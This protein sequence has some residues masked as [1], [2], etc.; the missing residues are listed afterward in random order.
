MDSL[1]NAIFTTYIQM[2]PYLFIG[3]F[4]A[5]FMHLV[6]TRELVAKHLGSNNTLSVIKAALLGVP[7]PLCSCGVIPTT[8]YLRKQK[9][10]P[11]AT[12]SF[13]ISTPQTGIDSVV[14]TYGLMGPVFAIF[15]PIAAFVTGIFGGIFINHTAPDEQIE[16]QTEDDPEATSCDCESCQITPE[17]K[18]NIWKKTYNALNYAYVEFLDDIAGHLILGIIIAGFIAFFIPDNFFLKYGGDGFLGMLLMIVVGLP[19]YVCA[20]SSIPIAVSLMLKGISPGAA[21]VFLVV[22][23]AT[24]AATITLIAK[25]MGKKFVAIYL[26]VVSVFAVLGGFL[27]NYIFSLEAIPAITKQISLHEGVSWFTIVFTGLFTLVLIPSIYRLL[28][29]KFT[30]KG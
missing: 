12:I 6:F 13:L 18:P 19:M 15:R 21:F 17:T 23:P 26:G 9:A 1:W 16:Q 28:K 27:L 30:K 20:T 10:S 5:G 3:L 25:T 29:N 14:A 24:N 22:G 8:L 4:F 11:G 2:A 7:L